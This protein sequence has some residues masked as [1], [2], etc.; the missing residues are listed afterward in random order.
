[1][2]IRQVFFSGPVCGLRAPMGSGAGGFGL[3]LKSAL[4]PESVSFFRVTWAVD[5]RP[6]ARARICDFGSGAGGFGLKNSGPCP[7][8][9]RTLRIH[10]HLNF[11]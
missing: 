2:G 5:G 1:M 6:W 11:C 4:N 10:M 9:I 3:C 8:L 7:S